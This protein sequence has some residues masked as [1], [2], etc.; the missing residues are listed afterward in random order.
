MPIFN[1]MAMIIVLICGAVILN[2]AELYAWYEMTY[3]FM[4]AGCSAFGIALLV[5]KPD[6]PEWLNKLT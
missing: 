4:I 5:K 2:E 3:I 1:V 6:D